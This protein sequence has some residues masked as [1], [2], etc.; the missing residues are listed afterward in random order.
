MKQIAEVKRLRRRRDSPWGGLLS[1]GAGA[2]A[3]GRLTSGARSAS[4]GY[5]RSAR[6]IWIAW[7]G[8]EQKGANHEV[9]Q[10]RQRNDRLE[11]EKP[12]RIQLSIGPWGEPNQT[13]THGY[14]FPQEAVW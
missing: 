4:R 11:G 10:M 14:R 9:S 12:D 3:M 5:W 13:V 6:A 1:F 7:K 2:C 8:Y